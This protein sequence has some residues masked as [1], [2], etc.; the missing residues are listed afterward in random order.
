MTPFTFKLADGAAASIGIDVAKVR[1][2]DPFV[3]GAFGSKGTKTQRT[4]LIARAAREMRRPAKNVVMRDKGFTLTAYRAET[5]HRVRRGAT[6]DCKLVAYCHKGWGDASRPDDYSVAGVET[7]AEMYA[8]PNVWTSVNLVKADRITPGFM[9]SPPETPFMYALESTM[10]EMA[11]ALDVD[12]IAFR[13]VNDTQKNP[14]SGLAYTSRSLMQC[15]DEAAA[16]FRWKDRNPKT[17]GARDRASAIRALHIALVGSD[18]AVTLP[19]E[20]AC[21][22]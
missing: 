19:D 1:A 12:P 17:V 5:K 18:Q 21:A 7:T 16:S 4:A 22:T 3:G 9:R 20:M 13:R 14:I 11:V 8:S 10:D 2:H 15:D 6:K